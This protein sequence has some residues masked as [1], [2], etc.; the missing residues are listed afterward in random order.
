LGIDTKTT[1]PE[2]VISE[3]ENG[4]FS[5][6]AVLEALLEAAPTFR[7]RTWQG[8]PSAEYPDPRVNHDWRGAFD[9]SENGDGDAVQDSSGEKPKWESDAEAEAEAGAAEED[10]PAEEPETEATEE[11]EEVEKVDYLALAKLA[12]AGRPK[13]EALAAA[14]TLSDRAKMLGIEGAEGM[15]SWVEVAEAIVGEE[16]PEAEEEE[17]EPQE[18]EEYQEEPEEWAPSEGEVCYLSNGA[19]KAPTECEIVK[20]Y[21]KVQKADVKRLDTKKIIKGVPFAKLGPDEIPF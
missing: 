14:K 7:F 13:K 12:D 6:G 9:Y 18:E 4:E 1:S 10:V 17:E 21:G 8:K 2:D 16:Q 20:V 5:S 3:A 15:A 11:P 19:K